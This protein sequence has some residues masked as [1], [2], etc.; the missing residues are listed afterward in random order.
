MIKTPNEITKSLRERFGNRPIVSSAT[1]DGRTYITPE[2]I[3]EYMDQDEPDMVTL[4]RD[5]LMIMAGGTG[6]GIEDDKT[7]AFVL[8]QGQIL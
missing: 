3:Q 1:S 6:Y 5:F 4:M 8:T 2:D 7:C